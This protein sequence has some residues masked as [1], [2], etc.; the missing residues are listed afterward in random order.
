MYTVNRKVLMSKPAMFIGSSTEGLGVARSTIRIL[1]SAF[2]LGAALAGSTSLNIAQRTPATR[3]PNIVVILTDDQGYGDL[4]SYGHPTI[5]TPNIDRLATEG[6]RWTSFYGAPVCTPSRAQLLTGRLAVRTGLASGVLFPDSQGGLQPDEVTIPEVLKLRGYA[7]MAIGKWHLGVLPQYLPTSQGFDSYFGIPYSNDM[8]MVADGDVPGG[9]FGGYMNPKTEYFRVP[10]M[11][12]EKIVERPADQTTITRRYTDEAISFIKANRMR[13]FFLYLA[14]N[15]PHMPLFRSKEFEGRSQRGK[16]GDVIEEL[17]FNVGRVIQ[18]LRDLQLDRNTL[19]VFTS[20]NGPWSPYL[21]QGGS[22]GLLR[23]AK[24]S[25]WEGGMREPA[26]FWWPGTIKPA[27]VTGIGS[28]LDLL[29]TFAALSDATPPSDR[30]LDGYDLSPTLKGGTPS[31]RHTIFYYASNGGYPAPL[32]AVRQGPYKLHLQVP[33]QGQRGAGAAAQGSATAPQGSATAAK[34]EL[35]NLDEDPSE[36]FD[37][38]E[39]RAD[40]VSELRRI[41]EEHQK[42]VTPGPNQLGRGQG[43]GR[44]SQR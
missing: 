26:I 42:N 5:R 35:Y 20:D 43:R 10:L 34:V 36:K 40:K 41:A 4:G 39:S 25:T 16:Y 6:Q 30:P 7:T 17:D 29:Q 33:Q 31:P 12:N 19:V 21:E 13:P 14:H 24:A 2:L 11:R 9:R 44:G 18:T 32:V 23:G 15:M 22:A 1:R 27:V 37:L 38:A 28:E 8:D 3:P